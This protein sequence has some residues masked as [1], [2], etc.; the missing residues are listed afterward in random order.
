MKRYSMSWIQRIWRRWQGSPSTI[1]LPPWA[2]QCQRLQDQ[3]AILD[4]RMTALETANP[5]SSSFP[6]PTE[7]FAVPDA[8]LGA[9]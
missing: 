7:A 4:A 3:M 6:S 5:T 1:V 2:S 8:H 9:Q